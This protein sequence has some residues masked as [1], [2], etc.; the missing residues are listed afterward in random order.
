M[1][2]CLVCGC[3]DEAACVDAATGETCA[4]I[5]IA[6]GVTAFNGRALCSFCAE[7]NPAVIAEMAGSEFQAALHDALDRG[8]GK[9]T[10]SERNEPLVEVFSDHEASLFLRAR[11]AG[12]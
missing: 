9:P 1:I 10:D 8:L 4:W 7:E 2:T 11:R 3:T 5:E 6:P 12:L